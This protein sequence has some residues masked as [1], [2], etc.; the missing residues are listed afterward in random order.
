MGNRGSYHRAL[1][2]DCETI[3]R[4]KGDGA[5]AKHYVVK[6]HDA[7]RNRVVPRKIEGVLEECPG[8]GKDAQLW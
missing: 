3:T 7:S 8:V 5:F 2:P 1:C 4:V 6:T